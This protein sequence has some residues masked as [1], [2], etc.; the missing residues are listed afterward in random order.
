VKIKFRLLREGG[1]VPFRITTDEFDS[2][3]QAS[4]WAQTMM[5][6]GTTTNLRSVITDQIA[7]IDWSKITI[8][9]VEP[10]E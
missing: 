9:N 5:K 3:I 4:R 2:V 6:N 8:A 1:E 7:V 10:M